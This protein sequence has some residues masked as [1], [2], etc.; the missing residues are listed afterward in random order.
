MYS[1]SNIKTVNIELTSQCQASCP[2]CSRNDR[3][4]LPNPLL[5]EDKISL[6]LY[7]HALPKD[8]LQ[9]LTSISFCGNFGDA[10]LNKD[11]VD[12]VRYTS[13]S[14]PNIHIDIYTNGS[15]RTSKWWRS[16]ADVLP[17]SHLV[18]FGIDGLEDTHSLYRVGTDFN[19]IIDN[20]KIFIAA[21]GNARWNF[22]TFKHNEHQLE[23]CKQLANELKFHSFFEMQTS[24]FI[25]N[26]WA[27]VCDNKGNVVYKLEEPSTRKIVFIE[28]KTVDQFK[29]FVKSSSINCEVQQT[30]SIY[31]DAL[32][33]AWP[34]S[35]VGAVPYLYS[36]PGDILLESKNENRSILN[37]MLEPF[38]GMEGLNLRNI[39]IKDLVNSEAWQSVWT[40]SFVNN[41]LPTCARQ[42]GKWEQPIMSQCRDQFLNLDTFEK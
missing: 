21:G 25:G 24:K 7:K 41:K 9:Q 5:K 31:I 35:W 17:S 10:I 12:I 33:Y 14:N 26:P 4:G 18:Q 8:F 38:G 19:K 34:C 23:D 11:L 2:M 1:Y 16:L 22:I 37:T 15:A 3:G 29:E 6:D 13:E 32:G 20:A 27:D 39:S 40:T 30:K 36:H 28:K 42:C